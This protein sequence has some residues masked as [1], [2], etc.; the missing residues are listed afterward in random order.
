MK[1]IPFGRLSNEML[2]RVEFELL[3]VS[4][5]VPCAVKTFTWKARA[6][7]DSINTM[8]LLGFGYMLNEGAFRL[9]ICVVVSHIPNMFASIHAMR[10]LIHD[11]K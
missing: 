10:S 7:G 1:Y 2:V 5:S 6:L 11:F 8:S 9:S 3:R 4:M